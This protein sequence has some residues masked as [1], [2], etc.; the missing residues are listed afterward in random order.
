MKNIKIIFILVFSGTAN[1]AVIHDQKSVSTVQA[2]TNTDCIYFQLEGV[3][4]ADPVVPNEPWFTVSAANPAKDSILSLA[5]A[6][7]ASGSTVRVSTSGNTAC[8]LSEIKYI[9]LVK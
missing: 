8:G 6:A 3:S 4:Q 7:Y 1:A 9:R 2:S 5:L